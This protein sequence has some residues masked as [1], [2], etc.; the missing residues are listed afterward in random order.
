[1]K[2][3]IISSFAPVTELFIENATS[4]E[5]VF[6]SGLSG[7]RGKLFGKEVW[8]IPLES[9]RETAAAIK[10]LQ[11]NGNV[12]C[13]ISVALAEPVFNCLKT[14]DIL[15]VNEALGTDDSD[16][17]VLVAYKGDQRLV[18]LALLAQEKMSV[19]DSSFRVLSGRTV[20][21][22]L[23]PEN[24]EEAQ[25]QNLFAVDAEGVELARVCEQAGLSC[26]QIRI[27]AP[28]DG[29]PGEGEWER[30]GSK[31]AYWVVKSV[32]EMTDHADR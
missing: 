3:A 25:A 27:M 31:N 2:I 26:V 29:S 11:A 6:W 18:D 23:M 21:P 24:H 9:G 7:L 28:A 4:S 15:V 5:P 22:A 30:E 32:L 19:V 1:M 8:I 17:S 12:D 13:L 10:L 14:G 20:T 16:S